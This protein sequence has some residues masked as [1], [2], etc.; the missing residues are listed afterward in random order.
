MARPRMLPAASELV[1]RNG[2][3]IRLRWMAIAG[4]V[5]ALLIA[6]RLLGYRAALLPI[7]VVLGALALYN[8]ILVI[9]V[10]R[11]PRLRWADLAAAVALAP[12]LPLNL[13][14]GIENL[15]RSIGVAAAGRGPSRGGPW[16]RNTLA[17]LLVPRELWGMDPDAEI[18]QAAKLASAQIAVDLTALAA[19]LHFSGGLENPLCFF[20]VFHA[21][22]A[23]ILLSRKAT[24]LFVTLAVGLLAAMG[25]GELGGLLRHYPFGGLAVEGGSGNTVY[26]LGRIL[27]LAGTLYITAYLATT[28][29]SHQRSYERETVLLSDEVAREAQMLKVAYAR[30]SQTERAKSQ[31]MRKVS[32]ELR[33]PL[34]TIQTALRV[35]LAGLA[36]HVPEQSRDLIS[37]A[38]RRAGELAELTRDLLA[39]SRAREGRLATEMVAVKL[40]ELVRA[41]VE[42]MGPAAAHAGVALSFKVAADLGEVQGDP[43]GLQQLLGNL[44]SNGIRYTPGGGTV[45]VRVRQTAHYVRFEV[46]DTGMGIAEEDVSRIFEDFFRSA[47]A[48]GRVPEGTGLGLSIV[49]AV[50]EEHGGS[51]AVESSVGRGTRFIIDLPLKSS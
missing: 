51:V 29:S 42:E 1:E 36:G 27:V 20:F 41:V 6:E 33:G 24:F 34:G 47:S 49:K 35:V 15:A 22:I 44:V 37:R 39:L 9:V 17:D 21:V 10:S 46:E 8:F 40:D 12:V 48:R 50:A 30:V 7:L 38:E 25:L 16:R 18:L 28:I 2:W 11:P 5:T 23:S 4:A 45:E 13:W 32:H 19:L 3:F 31:Y 14:L 43:A 26:V